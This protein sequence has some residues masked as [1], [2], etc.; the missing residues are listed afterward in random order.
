MLKRES[1]LPIIMSASDR[2]QGEI[3]FF[4]LWF[5]VHSTFDDLSLREKLVRFLPLIINSQSLK[6]PIT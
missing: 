2:Q 3:G 6:K 5:K 4:I 1:L